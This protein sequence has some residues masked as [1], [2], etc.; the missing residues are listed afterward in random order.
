MCA[1]LIGYA[2]VAFRTYIS[3]SLTEN[4]YREAGLR[5]SLRSLSLK[6]RSKKDVA[7][8]VPTALQSL[9]EGPMSPEEYH[10]YF[11]SL[12]LKEEVSSGGCGHVQSRTV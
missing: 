8:A 5:R 9:V 12:Y 6:L 4:R 7:E 1:L 3:F 10:A 2:L 11:L